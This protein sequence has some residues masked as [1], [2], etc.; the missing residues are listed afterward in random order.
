MPGDSVLT[1]CRRLNDVRRRLDSVNHKIGTVDD[2]IRGSLNQMLLIKESSRRAADLT[3][4]WPDFESLHAKYFNE[5]EVAD[6]HDVAHPDGLEEQAR[7]K[8]ATSDAR[9]PILQQNLQDSPRSMT[10]ASPARLVTN[11][12]NAARGR[13]GDQ[14]NKGVALLAGSGHGLPTW[15]RRRDLDAAGRELVDPVTR[16][17][18]ALEDAREQFK[19]M[20]AMRLR[21]QSQLENLA[22]EVLLCTDQARERRPWARDTLDEVGH[23]PSEYQGLC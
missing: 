10:T 5:P 4:E 17:R 14:S 19:K 23:A 11:N 16:A 12:G 13:G 9:T 1:R 21:A 15:S 2:T 3:L 7:D 6:E 8:G 22:A 20:G 18:R